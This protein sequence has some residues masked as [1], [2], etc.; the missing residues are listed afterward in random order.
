MIKYYCRE[1]S[2]DR[3]KRLRENKGLCQA[4]GGCGMLAVFETEEYLQIVDNYLSKREE[5]NSITN[6]S[7]PRKKPLESQLKGDVEL[8]DLTR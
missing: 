4:M 5:K 2:F 6:K 1:H 8:D 3:S 7:S